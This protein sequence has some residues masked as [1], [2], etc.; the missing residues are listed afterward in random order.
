METAGV[1]VEAI[2]E[3]V[4]VPEE[5]LGQAA[6]P[7]LEPCPEVFVR[8]PDLLVGERQDALQDSR[9]SRFLLVEAFVP[10][11]EQAGHHAGLVG[12]DVDRAA[13]SEARGLPDHC[14]TLTGEPRVL[15]RRKESERRL[16]ALVEI[17]TVP[18]EAVKGSARGGSHMTT[19]LSLSP[20]NQL[21]AAVI[22]STHRWS[23]STRF[24]AGTGIGKGR[25]LNGLLVESRTVVIGAAATDG[26]D[27]EV[28]LSGLAGEQPVQEVQSV[29]QQDRTVESRAGRNDRFGERGVGVG[30]AWLGPWPPRMLAGPDDCVGGVGQ[31]GCGQTCRRDRR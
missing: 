16:G 6:M 12:R 2:R 13:A 18:L 19:P 8:S 26:G 29:L 20:R 15:Q 21:V 10:R 25:H 28:A 30:E 17:G 24:G 7:A 5:R 23:P 4:G 31:E 9:G 1:R 27:G 22:P 14:K 11:D 3:L